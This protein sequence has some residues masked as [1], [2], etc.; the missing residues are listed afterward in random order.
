MPKEEVPVLSIV[1]KKFNTFYLDYIR[2]IRN[3]WIFIR[4]KHRYPLGTTLRFKM[5]VAALPNELLFEGDVVYHGKN[6]LG[7]DGV[8]ISL[9]RNDDERKKLENRL[10]MLVKDRFGEYWGGKMVA[11]LRYAD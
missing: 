5:K 8:G 9:R 1:Y 11:F 2:T 7:V 10:A 3:D 4:M 6:D